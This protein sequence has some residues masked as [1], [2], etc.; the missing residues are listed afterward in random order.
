MFRSAV[1]NTLRAP[2]DYT[3]SL[4]LMLKQRLLLGRGLKALSERHF[5]GRAGPVTLTMN[6]YAQVLSITVPPQEEHRYVDAGEVIASA[7]AKDI[8][9]AAWD[10]HRQLVEAKNDVFRTTI[11]QLPELQNHTDFARWFVEDGSSLGPH[12]HRLLK[13]TDLPPWLA[14]L[15]KESELAAVIPD[16]KPALMALEDS[17]ETAAQQHR[18]MGN[19][20]LQFWSRVELIRKAQANVIKGEKRSYKDLYVTPSQDYVDNVTLAFV[21]E[22]TRP[23]Q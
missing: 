19:D 17:R 14:E 3:N 2:F 12:P 13:E 5:T 8:Q 9:L 20:E 23:I 1:G 6:V 16:L 10:A 7:L 22:K 4:S 11:G 21:D 18:A 15:R